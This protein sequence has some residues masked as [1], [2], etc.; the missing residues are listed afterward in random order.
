MYPSKNDIIIDGKTSFQKFNV[1]KFKL[2]TI[3]ILDFVNSAAFYY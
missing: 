3:A 2:A 1:K